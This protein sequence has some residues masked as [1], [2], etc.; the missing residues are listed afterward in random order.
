MVSVWRFVRYTGRG[1]SFFFFSS[2]R[3]HTRSDRDW[4]SEVCSSDLFRPRRHVL[5]LGAIQFRCRLKSLGRTEQH[6]PDDETNKRNAFPH[7]DTLPEQ[8]LRLSAVLL[9]IT[10]LACL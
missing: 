3:R 2:R 5:Q 7:S 6:G 10:M 8:M 4:S 1:I 9:G